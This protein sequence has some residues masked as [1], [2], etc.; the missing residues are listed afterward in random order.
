M[1]K[2][3][4]MSAV[5]LLAILIAWYALLE[6]EERRAR[7]RSG[8]SEQS[9][10]KL[11]REAKRSRKTVT[12]MDRLQPT[13]PHV[14][15]PSP[16]LLISSPFFC[17]LECSPIM[18]CDTFRAAAGY[19]PPRMSLLTRRARGRFTAKPFILGKF[20]EN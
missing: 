14:E 7:K 12:E 20:A 15:R 9:S 17:K 6:Y 19:T 5:G 8:R 4:I 1:D 18:V 16:R 13:A 3:T 10:E 11:V 2:T